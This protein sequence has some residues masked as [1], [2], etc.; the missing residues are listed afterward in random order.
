MIIAFFFL[1]GYQTLILYNI[2]GHLRD[3]AFYSDTT[4][5][6]AFFTVCILILYNIN[7]Y[8]NENIIMYPGSKHTRFISRIITD[9]I[10]AIAFMLISF[11]FNSITNFIMSFTIYKSEKTSIWILIL[12]YILSY[13]F[14]MV[15]YSLVL[16]I[17]MI[18]YHLNTPSAICLF[19][20][21]FYA[22]A[23]N[24]FSFNALLN[25]IAN[26]I[27]HSSPFIIAIVIIVIEIII[28]S[29]CYLS[30]FI[31]NTT[32]TRITQIKGGLSVYIAFGVCTLMYLLSFDAISNI[33][34]SGY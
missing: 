26:L 15:L 9:H 28:L 24:Y 25:N 4:Y 3:A 18:I 8:S 29:I 10:I 7:T 6:F 34:F 22:I 14:A 21:S 16:F 5:G 12:I 31:P 11:L 2:Y 32:K 17:N 33:L 20:I 13:I 30:V 23:F 19:I 27:S 1:I